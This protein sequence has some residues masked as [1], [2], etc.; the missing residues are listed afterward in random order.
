VNVTLIRPL[1][2]LRPY[3]RVDIGTERR[4]WHGP[5]PVPYHQVDGREPFGPAYTTALLTDET[6]HLAVERLQCETCGRFWLR[7]IGVRG[8][9]RA[10]CSDPCDKWHYAWQAMCK[11]IDR[12]QFPDTDAGDEHFR[13]WR[14]ELWSLINSSFNP[15]DGRARNGHK[16][17]TDGPAST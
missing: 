11:A 10:R 2:R 15:R 14:S 13:L 17:R 7:P 3:Y 4:P 6:I 9:P 1:R 16:R 8:Q 12:L 5:R